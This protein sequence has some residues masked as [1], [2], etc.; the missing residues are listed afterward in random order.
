MHLHQCPE[1][2]YLF[3]ARK[4]RRCPKC[5]VMIVHGGEWFTSDHVKE[6]T[7]YICDKKKSVRGRGP[8]AIIV[9]VKLKENVASKRTNV[10]G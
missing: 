6:G 8:K 3:R 10:E 1:C 2:E 7:V 5:E 9:P 4:N